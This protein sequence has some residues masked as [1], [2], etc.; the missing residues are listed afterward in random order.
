MVATW[1]LNTWWRRE[2]LECIT[3]P[4]RPSEGPRAQRSREELD[5]NH[6]NWRSRSPNR[7]AESISFP[8]VIP[9]SG[10]ASTSSKPESHPDQLCQRHC[11]T[12]QRRHG[13]PDFDHHTVSRLPARLR[14]SITSNGQLDLLRL[15]QPRTRTGGKRQPSGAAPDGASQPL[16]DERPLVSGTDCG[17]QHGIANRIHPCASRDDRLAA[18]ECFLS[19][20][21][22]Q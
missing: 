8:T 16:W 7:E 1:V 11:R 4:A 14:P 9:Q 5:Q 17:E 21:C 3:T 12:G 2:K 18:G 13:P 10:H 15:S 19:E 22:C 20:G 6:N